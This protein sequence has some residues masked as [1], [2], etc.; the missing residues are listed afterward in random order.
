MIPGHLAIRVDADATIG[1]GH[2]MHASHWQGL[3]VRRVMSVSCSPTMPRQFAFAFVPK[4]CRS[5][6]SHAR[7]AGPTMRLKPLPTASELVQ[8]GLSWMDTTSGP[9]IKRL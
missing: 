3:E 5:N 1:A 4:G 9:C 8:T 6:L 7:A 2:V